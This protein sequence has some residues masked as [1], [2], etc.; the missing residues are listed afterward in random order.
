MKSIHYK[1]AFKILIA[2]A[3]ALALTFLTL[4]ILGAEANPAQASEQTERIWPGTALAPDGIN[5]LP[6]V[7]DPWQ[8]AVITSTSEMT[9]PSPFDSPGLPDRRSGKP[10][11]VIDAPPLPGWIINLIEREEIGAAS[12]DVV[13][14]QTIETDAEDDSVALNGGLITYTITISNDRDTSLTNIFIWDVLPEPAGMI[15]E[16]QCGSPDCHLIVITKTYDVRGVPIEVTV[17]HQISWF[18]SSLAGGTSTQK[19]FTGRIACQPDGAKF[20][21]SVFFITG[22]GA[23]GSNSAETVARVEIKE[24][25]GATLSE[26]PTWCSNEPGA[27]NDLDWA[28]VDLDGDLDLAVG[29]YSFGTTAYRNDKGRLTQFWNDSRFW[30]MGVRWADFDNDGTPELLATGHYVYANSPDPD[31]GDYWYTGYNYVY[32]Y[33]GS[34]FQLDDKG[35]GYTFESSDGVFRVAAADYDQDGDLDLATA[36]YYGGCT[37][38]LYKNQGPASLGEFLENLDFSNGNIVCLHSHVAPGMG[39]GAYSVAWGDYDND[40]D[41]DLAAGVYDDD[42]SVYSIWV[43][44]NTTTG[45]MTRL[46]KITVASE[47]SAPYNLAWGDYDRD[48]YLDL[49]AAFP[50]TRQVRIYENDYQNNRNDPFH[51]DPIT[52]T[53]DEYGG[54]VDWGDFDGDGWIDLAVAG[55]QPKIYQYHTDVRAFTVMTTLPTNTTSYNYV[56]NIRGIDYDNDGDLDLALSATADQSHLFTNFAPFLESTLLPVADLAANSV[57]WGDADGDGDLDLLFGAGASTF[58]SELY[59]NDKGKFSTDDKDWDLLAG[60]GPRS[61]AF[62]DLDGDSDLDIAFATSGRT[63]VYLA[64]DTTSPA[65]RSSPPNYPSKSI[66]WGD[67]D[68]DGDLDL[69]VGNDGPNVLYL[70]LGMQLAA[71]PVWTSTE[72]DTT[73]SIAWGDYNNDRYLDFAVGNYNQPNR[74]YRNN[75]DSTFTPV[76]ASSYSSQTTSVAWADYDGD[77]D[78]D[79]AVGNKGESNLIYENLTI[80]TENPTNTLQITP[81]WTSTEVFN[82]TSLAWG[83]WDNDGDLDLAVGNN[84]QVDQVYANLGSEPGSPQLFW[85][86][87]SQE[88]LQTTDVAWGDL[89]GDGDLDLAISRQGAGW[90]GVYTNTYVSPSHLTD[91]FARTMPLPNNPSYLSIERPGNT[92][93][94]YFFSSAERLSGALN[95]TVTIRYKLFDPDGTRDTSVSNAPGD[96]IISTTYEFSLDGGGTWDP[97]TGKPSTDWMSTA[98]QGSE[99]TFAWNAQTDQAISDDA[100]FRITVLQQSG[101]GLIKRPAISAISPPFR[102]MGLTCVWPANPSI[103]FSPANPETGELVRFEGAVLEGSGILTF[104]WNFGDGSKAIGQVVQHSYNVSNTYVVTLTVNGYPCPITEPAV[105]TRTITVSGGVKN[106]IYLPLIHKSARVSSGGGTVGAGRHILYFPLIMKSAT[107]VIDTGR[108]TFGMLPA[109]ETGLWP[110]NRAGNNDAG[111]KSEW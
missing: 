70:N 104:T 64:G 76:W 99:A 23:D 27:T 51:A 57:A 47:S 87:S 49:A 20:S 72:T 81:V 50:Y 3:T 101:T 6:R 91:D 86:W 9:A 98:R 60:F 109:Q 65:W 42:T 103:S 48:G 31:G 108:S 35:E 107:G 77:G 1:T 69:L 2:G 85:L 97:A 5:L 16:I 63:E 73:H 39:S 94:A 19:S 52:L 34:S 93:S 40:G 24:G 83:D 36:N 53:T 79:L 33:T 38:L 32:T 41:Q 80:D 21:N 100:R 61:V 71:S 55:Q 59:Y 12:E 110:P 29:S 45:A 13:I 88:V 105:I 58:G 37:L 67:A 11:G 92:D 43:F 30:T 95:P 75:K 54:A 26:G 8:Q 15:D 96:N 28:D 4:T 18:I 68:D 46:N 90:N 10:V 14:F 44:T 62:G 25:V 56:Y 78:L 82:T 84:D 74:V 89:D 66:A 102:V 111:R 17:T 7:Q 22:E 106:P